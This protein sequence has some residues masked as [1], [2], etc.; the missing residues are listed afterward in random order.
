MTDNFVPDDKEL[1][2]LVQAIGDHRLPLRKP[3]MEGTRV[4]ILQ[5]I[6]NEIKNVYG[7]NVI[8][9]R[10]FPGVGKS[11]LAASIANWLV[12]E[13][14][15]VI[16]FRFDRTDSTI[17]TSTLWRAVAC[18]LARLYPSLR[19]C[20]AQGNQRLS[21]SDIGL[22]F[23]LLIEEPLST[24][25]VTIPCEELPVI[26]ID[27][28][29][30][31][32]GLRH[33]ASGKDD[34]QSLLRT[35][36]QWTQV[37]HLKRFKLVVTSRPESHISQTFPETISFHITVPS[38]CDV[39]LEDSASQDI[40]TFLE[41]RLNHMGME[42]TWIAKV[43]DYLVPGA[44][45]VFIWATAVANFLEDDPEEHF[46]ILQ[47]RKGGDDIKAMDDLFS[48]YATVVRTASFGQILKQEVQGIVSV[49]GAMIYAK[50][51]LSD[52]V[53]VML[54]GVKIGKSD[55]MPLI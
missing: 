39:K 24:L 2:N 50:Q 25:D 40:H 36:K 37:D 14:R 6:E 8:W 7:P 29:D 23:E 46:H 52:D 21:S 17:T 51:P 45:G 38:G 4:A 30:E 20:L 34:F 22:L 9:I 1:N 48:L 18:D 53:L 43:L 3:C 31:C 10:G 15:H 55:V 5:D 54:P 13:K 47:S 49:M 33:D 19:R 28:L 27:A 26:V 41:S 11:A 35:L 42:S 32:G 16:S 12:D 44:A